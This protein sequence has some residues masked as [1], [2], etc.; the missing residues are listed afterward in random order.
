MRVHKGGKGKAVST[1]LYWLEWESLRAADDATVERPSAN[2]WSQLKFRL[3]VSLSH[4]LTLS[5]SRR[6]P[7]F[8]LNSISRQFQMQTLIKLCRRKNTEAKAE[9]EA[10]AHCRSGG[11]QIKI[12][13]MKWEDGWRLG[14]ER[15]KPGEWRVMSGKVATE[16]ERGKREGK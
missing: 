11:A 14:S 16:R 13:L 6:L 3:S 15:V 4:S 10:E 12:Q 1:V 8:T 5:F 7:G 9:A 2:G